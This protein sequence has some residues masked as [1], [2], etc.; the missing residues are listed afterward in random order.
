MGVLVS[1]LGILYS[2][3]FQMNISTY[4]PFLAVG[5]IV[6]GLIGTSITSSCTVFTGMANSIRQVRLPMS[7]HIFQFAWIQ[8]ITFGH[9]FVI[10]IFV[11]LFFG[12]W[13]GFTGLL[14]VPALFLI[15]LNIM[16][17]AMVLGPLSARFRDIPMIVGSL[18]QIA[19]FV[20]PILWS[21]EKMPKRTHFLGLNPFYHFMEIAREPLLGGAAT[22]NNWIISIAITAVFGMV[23]IT[24]FS[25]I[26]GRIAYW[27]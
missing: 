19:F 3:I 22:L 15:A 6:W 8:F 11:A 5:F 4:L 16:F 25:H 7:V 12:I 1:A 14:E 21:A 9:N 24:F 18:V 26:R 23:A 13:P 10:Y 20:T 27:V 2:E 17:C